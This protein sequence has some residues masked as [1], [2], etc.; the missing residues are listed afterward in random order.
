MSEQE[1]Q[2]E[3][4]KLARVRE[5]LRG[6]DGSEPKNRIIPLALNPERVLGPREP[7][8]QYLREFC[9]TGER[10]E[11]VHTA[12]P[13]RQGSIRRGQTGREE[14]GTNEAP[15]N[16]VLDRKGEETGPPI[17]DYEE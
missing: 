13:D 2:T 1:Q 15:M 11:T 9:L 14:A 16:L 12:H 17:F 3:P 6:A 7:E 5:A 10:E 8:E 4:T